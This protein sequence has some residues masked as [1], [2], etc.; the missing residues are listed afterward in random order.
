M[1]TFLTFAVVLGLCFL[2]FGLKIFFTKNGKFP[3]TEV[4]HNNEMR[5]RGIT[6]TRQDEFEQWRKLRK[7]KPGFEPPSCKGCGLLETCNR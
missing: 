4:G 2:G 5:K 1:I 6:C 7:Q 3:E